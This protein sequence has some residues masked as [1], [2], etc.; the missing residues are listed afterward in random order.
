MRS[1]PTIVIPESLYRGPR[2]GFTTADEEATQKVLREGEAHTLNPF[3]LLLW[4]AAS[5]CSDRLCEK[6]LWVLRQRMIG[7]SFSRGDTE[8]TRVAPETRW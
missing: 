7:N 5:E 6:V 8:S 2:H 1:C 3:E 4:S